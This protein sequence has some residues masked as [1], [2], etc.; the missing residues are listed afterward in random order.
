MATR[1]ENGQQTGWGNGTMAEALRRMADAEPELAARLIVQSLPVAAAPLPPDLSWRL[2]VDGVGAW[3]VTGSGNGGAARVE[4][5][6]TADVRSRGFLDRHRSRRPRQPRRRLEPAGADPAPQ[7]AAAR[8]AAKG[9]H[10]ARDGLRGRPRRAG[11]A[12]PADRSRSALP[13][14]RL[15]I[16]P[17]VD[18]RP[19]LRDRLRALRRRR[20]ALDGRG[21]RRR[22][23]RPEAEARSRGGRAPGANGAGPRSTRPCGSRSRPGGGCSAASCHR[24]APPSWG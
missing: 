15:R 1:V 19:P 23:R 17:R 6:P 5:A 7:A 2:D 9:A 11:Q 24:P 18:P 10:P 16:R 22:G 14:A 12:R 8:E 3:E 20:W 4:S 21:G 13:L